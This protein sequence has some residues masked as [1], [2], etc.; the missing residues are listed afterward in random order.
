LAL[1][2]DGAGT[3]AAI[4]AGVQRFK[5]GDRVYSYSWD[6]PK[7]GFYAEYVAVAADMVGHVP[8]GLDLQQA[9]A[10]PTTGLTAL[11]GVDDALGLKE[12]MSVIIHGASGAVGTL[13]VQFARLRGAR[14]LATAS[15]EDGV[16]L[17]R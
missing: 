4:G 1:G 14:V 13:A 11:Q 2:V 16:A 6:N 17:V 8:E 12:G 7:G 9:G 10:I 15:G 3:V 5:V